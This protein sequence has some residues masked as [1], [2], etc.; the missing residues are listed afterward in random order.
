MAEEECEAHE[1]SD[2]QHEPV[3]TEVL[4][5]AAAIFRAAGDPGRLRIRTGER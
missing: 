1:H 3:K 5:R 2:R 4:E